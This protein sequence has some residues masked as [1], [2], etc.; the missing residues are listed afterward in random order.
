MVYGWIS[1]PFVIK[2]D[3]PSTQFPYVEK[4]GKYDRMIQSYDLDLNNGFS[5][6]FLWNDDSRHT[7]SYPYAYISTNV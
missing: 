4:D 3:E 1:S 6:V 5:G 7:F 2:I